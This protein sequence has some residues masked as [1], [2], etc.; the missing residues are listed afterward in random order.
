MSE[1]LLVPA[2]APAVRRL[3]P[4][5]PINWR[6]RLAWFSITGTGRLLLRTLFRVKL[7]DMP[8]PA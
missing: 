8:P 4:L 5:Q 7:V 2:I 6:N 3:H 1:S